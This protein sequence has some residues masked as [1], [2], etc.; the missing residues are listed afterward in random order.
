MMPGGQKGSRE[1]GH[2]VRI[3]SAIEARRVKT[4][5]LRGLIHESAVRVPTRRRPTTPVSA[6]VTPRHTVEQSVPWSDSEAWKSSNAND[7]AW[8]PAG[9][10]GNAMMLQ[11][12]EATR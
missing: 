5:F 6:T 2:K 10:A 1:I 7:L 8:I 3:A 9:M 4:R 11:Q 12:A